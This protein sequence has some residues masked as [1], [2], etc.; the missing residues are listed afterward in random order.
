[1]KIDQNRLKRQKQGFQRWM[2]NNCYG[3]FQ[4]VT[5]VG[6]TF[7][8][9]LC[10]KHF[11]E[12]LDSF[13]V[14]VVVPTDI[15]RNSWRDEVK[16][17]GIEEHFVIDTVHNLVRMDIECDML[18][19]D[20]IHMYVGD[21]AEVFP[22][23][24]R[25]INADKILGLTATLGHDGIRRDLVDA[26]CPVVDTIDLQEA[27]ENGYVSD[28]IE[29][30]LPIQLT[31][32]E[33]QEYRK[34]DK[35]FQKYFSAFYNNM[36]V[37]AFDLCK[38]C[39]KY[40]K[41]RE[42][43][44]DPVAQRFAQT[45]HW[46]HKRLMINAVNCMKVIRERKQFLYSA[47]SKIKTAKQIIEMF[48]NKKFITFAQTTDSADK[49]ADVLD[50]AMSYHSN[51]TTQ[52]VDEDENIIGQKSGKG[53]YVLYEHGDENLSWKQV[54]DLTNGH[55]TRLG[56]K[57]IKEYVLDLFRSGEIRGLCTA[58]AF[59]VGF[60]E[61]D[62]ELA[63]VLSGTSKQRQNTQRIGRAIRL[64]EGKRAL[65]IQLYVEDTQEEKWLNERQ[66]N[67]GNVKDIVST[68]QITI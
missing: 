42:R 30:N 6:K 3:T 5:G 60:D 52:L 12:K 33:R 26:N 9:I 45:I 39:L 28:Y 17:H 36:G 50:D 38:K 4:W 7:A 24:F 1:M 35:K 46:S 47:P 49:L 29:Y 58:M 13:E 25:K 64:A 32:Q 37:P 31:P 18:I 43:L 10:A 2:D 53:T 11:I 55:V 34:L 48:P 51:I 68:S 54:K 59:D 65:I 66:T 67:T 41:D 22:D 15:L 16:R 61:Q 14:Y 20:E 40:D 62:I 21:E 27:L 56:K 19:L 57:R 23:I 44:I 63:V 8:A